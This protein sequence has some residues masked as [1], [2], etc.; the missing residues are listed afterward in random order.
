MSALLPK[1]ANGYDF[2]EG[3]LFFNVNQ[4]GKSVTPKIRNYHPIHD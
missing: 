2:K 1:T 3:G 4:D